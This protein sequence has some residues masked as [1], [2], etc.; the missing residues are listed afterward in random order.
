MRTHYPAEHFVGLLNSQPMG[1]YSPRVLLNE[2]RRA[3]IAILPPDIHLSGEGCTVEDSGLS[4]RIGFSYCKGLSRKSVDGILAERVQR[5][6]A[7][8][9]DLYHRTP[10]DARALSNLIKG[11]FLDSLGA[12]SSG[13]RRELLDAVSRL[14][15]LAF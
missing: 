4:I 9:A 1:F 5:P 3:E 14:P 8:V 15:K 10:V 11:G 12:S 2:A 6:F 13:R 7:S